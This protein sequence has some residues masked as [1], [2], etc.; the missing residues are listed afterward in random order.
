MPLLELRPLAIEDLDGIV[1]LDQVCLGGFWSRQSYAQELVK[2]HH[3][4]LVLAT[5]E[6]IWG[7]G[8]TWGIGDELHLVLLMVHPHCRRQGL[9]GL[10][11][12]R[13]LQ[14]AHQRGD[15]QWAT[16]EVRPSNTAALRLYQ[17]F[18]FT[19]VGRRPH[20]YD[21]PREDA[22]ILWRNHLNTAATGVTL[23]HQWHQWQ[24]RVSRHGW[25]VVTRPASEGCL[26]GEGS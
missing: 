7:C 12:C 15:R 6:Q 17:Q 10:L 4:L 2:P 1:Q 24:T 3:T 9:A 26:Q 20:Y 18:E 22:L 23:G 16:L 13:L 5:L 25:Q 14:L 11:L 21:H 8:L 19:V